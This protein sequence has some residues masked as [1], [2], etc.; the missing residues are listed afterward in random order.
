MLGLAFIFLIIAIIAAV[1]RYKS[2]V[3]TSIL[4]AKII[5]CF[6]STLFLILLVTVIFNSLPPPVNDKAPLAI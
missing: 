2:D 5:F 1:V 6:F 3:P 4:I